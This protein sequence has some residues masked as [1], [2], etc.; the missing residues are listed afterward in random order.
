MGKRIISQA[1]GKGSLTYRVRKK[2]FSNKVGYPSKEG[3]AEILKIFHSPAHSAPLMKI[4]VDNEVFIADDIVRCQSILS[5]GHCTGHVAACLGATL[6]TLG[7]GCASK[8]GKLKQNTWI[9][10]T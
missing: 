4:K 2:A 10:G 5:V 3:E 7:M 8:K 6:K 1:R 9:Y